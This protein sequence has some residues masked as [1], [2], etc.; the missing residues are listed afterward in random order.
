MAPPG[1][2]QKP[3]EFVHKFFRSA[4]FIRKSFSF[5]SLDLSSKRILVQASKDLF[6]TRFYIKLVEPVRTTHIHM[7]EPMTP[8]SHVDGILMPWGGEQPARPNGGPRAGLEY[9]FSLSSCVM[10]IPVSCQ[11]P[12]Q[13][14]RLSGSPGNSYQVAK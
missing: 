11:E 1:S 8:A 12:S 10:I 13:R 6:Q 9:E 5:C 14:N 2:H 3:V 7:C 4:C